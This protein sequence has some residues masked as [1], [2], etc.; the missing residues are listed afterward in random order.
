MADKARMRVFIDLENIGL[1]LRAR[2]SFG[3]KVRNL[4]RGIR[5]HFEE[6]GYFV[7]S[8][9][10]CAIG[11]THRWQIRQMMDAA[12]A[13]SNATMFWSERG[14]AD[15]DIRGELNKVLAANPRPS[16]VLLV[17]GDNDFATTLQRLRKTGVEVLVAETL[18]TGKE[19]RKVANKL[20][21]FD[22]IS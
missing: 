8:I 9:W 12:F 14:I 7:E 13:E 22:L 1:P 5:N 21:P 18:D 2:R 20:I 17:S 10:G 3:H 11:R 6:N 16:S 19:L 4:L 15:F